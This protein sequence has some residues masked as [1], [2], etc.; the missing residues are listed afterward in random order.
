[1]VSGRRAAV[2]ALCAELQERGV[3]TTPRRWRGAFHSP[4]MDPMLEDFTR[5]VDG[6]RCGR[7]GLLSSRR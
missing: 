7:R 6:R 2:R 5:E 1:M 4:L 3:K